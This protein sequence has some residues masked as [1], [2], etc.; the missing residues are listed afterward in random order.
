MNKYILAGISFLAGAAASGI[1]AWFV[2]KKR[3]ERIHQ[4]EMNAVWNDIQKN[5][6]EHKE[7]PEKIL[8][9]FDNTRVEIKPETLGLEKPN[10]ADYANRIRSTGYGTEEVPK[11]D[12]KIYEIEYS[13]LDEDLYTRVDLMLYADGIVADDMDVPLR[14]VELALGSK[15]LEIMEG[16]DEAYIRNE[17]RHIDYDV[18][19]S[20]LSYGEML[21]RHPETEQRL[22]FNDAMDEYYS[23]DEEEEY[24]GDDEE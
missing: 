23:E 2:A 3:Y 24:E 1:T 7:S 15:Y 4:E 22:Q 19:R 13:D 10:L 12:N 5:K 6:T 18:C 16:K 8:E 14:D 11:T 20:L 17:N 21:D 9:E